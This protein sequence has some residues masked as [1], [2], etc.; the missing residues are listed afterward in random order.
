MAL[1][2]HGEEIP[3]FLTLG[4]FVMCKDGLFYSDKKIGDML[5]VVSDKN[6]NLYCNFFDKGSSCLDDMKSIAFPCH[7][8]KNASYVA[9]GRTLIKY[10]YIAEPNCEKLLGK[11][12]LMKYN[13]G[14]HK[15]WESHLLE[16]MALQ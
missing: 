10:G 3:D 2:L 15:E 1:G 7:L 6:G 9:L 16:P 14:K 5:Q 8:V 13:N 12:M 4:K 11:F